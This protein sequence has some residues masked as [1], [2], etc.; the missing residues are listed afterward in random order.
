[1]QTEVRHSRIENLERILRELL[2]IHALAPG[3][4]ACQFRLWLDLAISETRSQIEKM[5]METIH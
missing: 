3:A 4:Q 1:M 5:R 2:E